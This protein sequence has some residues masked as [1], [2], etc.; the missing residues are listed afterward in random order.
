[1]LL[2]CTARLLELLGTSQL[3]LVDD[4]P[5][6]DDWYANLLWLDRRKCVLLTHAG[7]LFPV[8]VG[9]VRKRDLQ[10]PG[11]LLA[12]RIEAALTDERLPTSLL[13]PLDPKA[14]RIART[15]SRSILGF[16]NDSALACRYSIEQAGGLEHTDLDDLN[17]FLRRQPHN[18][19]G[20]R[21]PLDLVVDRLVS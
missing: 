7:T 14:A 4:P 3:V 17:R 1:M 8:F 15:A 11:P 12:A 6:D 10:P 5:R 16:M 13:G 21:Q 9:D 20:Y 18:R 19:D 2:R